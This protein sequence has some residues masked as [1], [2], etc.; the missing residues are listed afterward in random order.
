MLIVLSPAKRLD[1]ESP[2]VS[3]EFTQPD[4][5][6]ESSLLVT[7]LRQRSPAD[8]SSLMSISDKLGALNAARFHTWQLPFSPDNARPAMLAFAGDVYDG[9][10][11]AT[12]TRSR[13][14]WAQQHLRI[15]SGLYGVLRPLD[16]I[17]PYR[18]EMGTRLATRRGGNLYEFWGDRITRSL[19]TVLADMPGATLV[20]LASE[21]Y[22]KAV[23][24]A[25]LA[26]PVIQPVFE[27]ARPE[28]DKPFA[29]V[30]FFAK[31]A[32]GAMARYVIEKRLSRVEAL[33]NFDR[34]GY[35]FVPAASDARRWVF[36][37]GG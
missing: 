2:L 6:D 25:L 34:D 17:Q 20:N 18:L 23:R 4:F 26:A 16:L 3:R 36:R 9:L 14:S 29:I 12:L 27:E 35:R 22:F 31:R 13:L 21:E 10:D 32:R 37:R 1:F 7:Q 24:P 19:N 8:L 30:S 15:L 28:G 11:A 33:K 5:L